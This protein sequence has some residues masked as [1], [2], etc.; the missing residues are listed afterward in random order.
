M[1]SV[2]LADELLAAIGT[3]R[4]Q[5]RRTAG[6]PW[7]ASTLTGAQ[8]ELLRVVRT[9]PRVSVA[10]AADT[11]GVAANTVSTLVGQLC[12][13]GLLRREPDE[14]DRRVARLTLTPSA[15]RRVQTWRDRR[16]GLVAGAVGEL[17][18]TDAEA[19]V[20]ALPAL[21]QLS[22]RLRTVSDLAKVDQ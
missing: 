2:A 1:D 13:D 16:S 7:P 12:A 14:A 19:L 21:H 8:L 17:P 9:R 10:E 20:A 11:L 4:R 3:L 15:R 18:P 5:V 6:R 22:E